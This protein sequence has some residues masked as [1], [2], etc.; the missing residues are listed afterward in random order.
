[1]TRCLPAP[2][3]TGKWH[4]TQ[5]PSALRDENGGAVGDVDA[6]ALTPH[7]HAEPIVVCRRIEGGADLF[8]MARIGEGA[9][10]QLLKAD[11][12]LVKREVRLREAD[13]R[14]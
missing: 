5:E 3:G 7:Q 8:Q 6:V 9:R 11:M 10:E 1:V 2:T 14:E 12:E 4:R 13:T